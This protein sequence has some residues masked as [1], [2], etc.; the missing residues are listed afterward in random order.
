MRRA[1]SPV[2]CAGATERGP[3][4][5]AS[6]LGVAVASGGD[7][8]RRGGG[9][10]RGDLRIVFLAASCDSFGVTTRSGSS[11]SVGMSFGRSVS[12]TSA[13]CSASAGEATDAS[14]SGPGGRS[15]A[16]SVRRRQSPGRSRSPARPANRRHRRSADARTPARR[17]RHAA[18]APPPLRKSTAAAKVSARCRGRTSSIAPALRVSGS[19]A[20]RG[21]RAASGTPSSA[22]SLILSSRRRAGFPARPSF[23]H[24]A[25]RGRRA[26]R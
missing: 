4:C 8:F 7:R 13:F 22:T 25:P 18:R 24:R 6:V 2:P 10:H 26:G 20:P 19:Q 11:V 5:M 15:V 1:L 9:L 23:R 21:D 3:S 12:L 14:A 17:R 16:S